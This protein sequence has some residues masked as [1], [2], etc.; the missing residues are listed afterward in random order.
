MKFDYNRVRKA[1][2]EIQQTHHWIMTFIKSPEVVDI[3]EDMEIKCTG[4][5]VPAAEVTH[6]EV[7]VG[8]FTYNYVGK[9]N[10]AGELTFTF[11]ED[12]DATVMSA[13]LKWL[14]AYWN[15]ETNN[16]TGKQAFTKE[17][18]AQVR[19]QL[20][21]PDDS[22]TQTYDLVD[23]LPSYEA[24]GELGQDAGAFMPTLTLKYNDWHWSGEKS[25]QTW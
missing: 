7:Q 16:T 21:A 4:V 23:C 19:I 17:L 5:G 14:D 12:T 2:G 6:T 13:I 1:M 18:Q 3:P 8:G 10:K 15:G 9:V 20:L 24:G 25:G 11:P 22:V